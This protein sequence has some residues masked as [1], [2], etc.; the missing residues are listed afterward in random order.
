[1]TAKSHKR[2]IVKCSACD[3][4][5]DATK[6]RSLKCPFCKF[7]MH[8]R[9]AAALG[10]IKPNG[11]L[12]CDEHVQHAPSNSKRNNNRNRCNKCKKL[13]FYDD[14]PIKCNNC[15]REYHYNCL[16]PELVE[17]LE[18]DT[19]RCENCSG[20][21]ENQQK[22][23]FDF[24]IT[25][26]V[27]LLASTTVDTLRDSLN[28][29][30]EEAQKLIK[31]NIAENFKLPIKISNATSTPE[32]RNDEL[33]DR[34]KTNNENSEEEDGK[35]SDINQIDVQKK[36]FP[37]TNNN[38]QPLSSKTPFPSAQIEN[39]RK[40]NNFPLNYNCLKPIPR[41]SQN[42]NAP[43]VVKN[44]EQQT[45]NAQVN[46]NE[47]DEPIEISIPMQDRERKRISSQ[48]QQQIKDP[49]VQL[50]ELQ[51]QHSI[52]SSYRKLPKINKIGYEWK[53]FYNAFLESYEFFT[54][55]ENV[56][57]LQEAIQCEEIKKIG[58]FTLFQPETYL[59]E[60]ENINKRIGKSEYLLAT[61]KHKLMKLE[62][63]S[64][65]DGKSIMEFFSQIKHY[66]ALVEKIGS[67]SDKIDK[68]VIARLSRLLPDKYKQKW[69]DRYEVLSEINGDVTINDLAKWL[70]KQIN[71]L[72]TNL[73]F[74]KLDPY[75]E[76]KFKS[77]KRNVANKPTTSNNNFKVTNTFNHH[78]NEDPDVIV[79]NSDTQ[80]ECDESIY[81][82]TNLNFAQNDIKNF[83]PI[84]YC[85]Y[86]N[87][88]GHSSLICYSLKAKTGKQVC[89]SAR[90][91]GICTICGWKNHYPCP[92]KTKIFCM[93]PECNFSHETI[94]CNKRKSKPIPTE[95]VAHD[96]I[97]SSEN[98]Q[99]NFDDPNET[100]NNDNE[101]SMLHGQHGD[102]LHSDTLWSM[103]DINMEST[104]CMNINHK[105][106]TSSSL[107]SVVVL[108][109]GDKKLTGAFLLDS[110]STVSVIEE[111]AA[112][113]LNLNGPK[114][115]IFIA[116]SGKQSRHDE[117]SKI[118]KTDAIGIHP[119]A[120]KYKIYFRTIKNL[121]IPNQVFNAEQMREKFPHLKN[122][123]L[124]SYSNIIGI[125]GTDQSWAFKQ[126][127]WINPPDK[128]KNGPIGITTPLGHTVIGSA[129][130]LEKLYNDLS[131]LSPD[132]DKVMSM[133]L[134]LEEENELI[135]MQENIL[136]NEYKNPYEDDR[137]LAEDELALKLLEEK[138]SLN[139]DG[140]HFEAPLLWKNE[141]TELPTKE[142]LNLAIKRLN[143]L[144]KH[145]ERLGK[146]SQIQDQIDNLISKGYAR[147]LKEEEIQTPVA[148]GF[149]IPIFITDP[150]TKRLRLIWDAAAK[151]NGKSLNDYLLAGPNLY[152]DL[153]KL[154]QQLREGKFFVKGDIQEMF[155][156]VRIIKEDTP[157]LRFVWRKSLHS[158]IE[159]YEMQVM[160]FGAICS[161][162]TSQFVKNKI[163]KTFID[164]YPEAATSII[165]NVYV[166]DYLKSFNSISEGQKLI[167]NVK[168]I[169]RKGGYNLIKLQGNHPDILK[170]IKE[171][172]RDEENQNEKLFSH[173][174]VE[175]LLGYNVNFH[176][177]SLQLALSFKNVEPRIRDGSINPTK[178]DVLK[179][180]MA[181]YDPLGLFQFYTSKL[182]LIY[183]H[184]CKEKIDWNEEISQN[185]L[186]NWKKCL[187]WLYEIEKIEIPRCYFKENELAKTIQLFVFCDAGKNIS[188]CVA[189]IR[190]LNESH[191]QLDYKIIG[192]KTNIVPLKQCRT[193][194]ELEL[195]AAAKGGK[196]ANEIVKNHSIKFN[197]I[198]FLTDN[199]CVFNWIHRGATKPTIYV[200]NRLNKIK[201]ISKPDQ[202]L[203]IPTELQTADFGTKFESLPE[204]NYNNDW[205]NPKLFCLAEDSWP[206][207]HPPI[208]EIERLNANQEILKIEHVEILNLERFSTF[209]KAIRVAQR[210]RKLKYVFKLKILKK[211]PLKSENSKLKTEYQSILSDENY[212]RTEI[213][214][215]IIKD[216]QRSSLSDEISLLEKGKPLPKSHYLYKHTPFLDDDG[217]MR[218]TTRLSSL[219]SNYSRDKTNPI[220]LPKNH[221]VTDLIILKYHASN[222][223][224]HHKTTVVR[225][226]QRFFIS[227]VNWKVKKVVKEQ[228][229]FCK[230]QNAKPQQPMMGDL[231]IEKL[232]SHIP[233][234]S[235]CIVD[236]CGPFFIRVKRSTEKRWLFVYSCL[237]TR[238]LHI[239]IIDSMDA[240]ACLIALQNT[241]NLRGAP[242]KIISDM[243]TNFV[244][245][246]NI[247]N[248]MNDK[249]NKKLLEKGIVVNP[250]EWEFTVA[251]G[252]YMNGSVERMVGLIKST[253]KKF[254]ATLN[255]KMIYP[256]DF[257]FRSLICEII[258]MINNRPL[259]LNPFEELNN[260]FLTPNH[261]ILQRDNFQSSPE[262][263]TYKKGYIK[264]WEEIK[265]LM[266]LLWS[267]WSLNYVT[268]I[269]HRSK[270]IESSKPL[271]VGDIVI[272]PDPSVNNLWRIGKIIEVSK[273][274]SN[275]VR[276]VIVRLGKR[277][278]ID[279]TIF[280]DKEKIMS[281]Y[282]KHGYY[283]V[284]RPASYVA[285]LNLKAFN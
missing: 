254:N 273:G 3:Q 220:I 129:M 26:V 92:N 132:H 246:N 121:E 176:N 88:Q 210:I 195:E 59:E 44:N 138:V 111:K 152:N 118:V 158:K 189:F 64:N 122:L 93:I 261:F 198:F 40:N 35:A 262:I 208:E 15:C 181:I 242:K 217:L 39:L 112:N 90:E 247:L 18:D 115:S 106:T 203:W 22:S 155:H 5:M 168:D 226:L 81:S 238:A 253:L 99:I 133:K 239:E 82:D 207:F 279:K 27:D 150:K 6:G 120:S 149:Y 274:S 70:D 143:I 119:N 2:K 56:F 63:V 85:W 259:S 180:M 29:P 68:S 47:D 183:H 225:L 231:P 192:S 241:I 265:I 144:S 73:L 213:E 4:F 78:L 58:G 36:S 1:M 21:N 156:Q 136:G 201:N 51:L 276:K 230:R 237:T 98:T 102:F 234:F 204:L 69:I 264:T 45:Q 50:T 66:A 153:V 215:N 131:K 124:A 163:A 91:K 55:T 41:N 196:Y 130:P 255:E 107:V 146:T 48:F 257:V 197:E 214:L 25:D 75:G 266:N 281:W 8:A 235:Y 42:Q 123:S 139:N 7:Y 108:K 54:H 206:T 109:L 184:L 252:S 52:K 216:A 77:T 249:W 79:P 256:N 13:L 17:K 271:E 96:K 228:C 260:S 175:K 171:K 160:I 284:T 224:I 32:K 178:K 104:K 28:I 179:F 135:K 162:V 53:T 101:L 126:L 202:W 194:P 97:K 117:N 80:S 84:N 46:E 166:D 43:N 20:E 94:F 187:K 258:G 23:S 127:R 49:I 277:G 209:D 177:D 222:N 37:V 173:A 182:K 125:I 263:V 62:K 16:P 167:K 165:E 145:A 278:P 19:W 221:R 33:S 172:L 283:E 9:C 280:N 14:G 212:K 60:L 83:N 31:N 200:N 174:P 116:W 113:Y 245:G 188:C 243:G 30:A 74:D 147:K 164:S 193:I 140:T 114:R 269:M 159:H 137:K 268:E 154:L 250:I 218:I 11:L 227:H 169:L 251:K 232:S 240:D 87:K 229:M 61:E 186:K 86:H 105:I 141:N 244:G 272:T 205:F 24:N 275:Q 134:S 76:I 157:A 151:I 103:R 270:W 219:N 191:Q 248:E 110:G 100:K 211:G 34:P 148:K 12:Y 71:S 233:P 223:H 67:Q 285:P 128:I 95:K 199:T 236:I 72:E 267:N 161:P 57:R 190:F 282:L 170:L 38:K 65:N 10:L 89:E 142:S 185:H